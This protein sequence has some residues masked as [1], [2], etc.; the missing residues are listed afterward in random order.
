[1]EAR[2]LATTVQLGKAKPAS[3]RVHNQR[4]RREDV[5]VREQTMGVQLQVDIFEKLS[6]M[7]G[8][9]GAGGTGVRNP[10]S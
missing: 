10:R 1:M 9:A 8:P 5:A 7:A 6:D 4:L 2:E 3:R